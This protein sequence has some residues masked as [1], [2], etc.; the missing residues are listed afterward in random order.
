MRQNDKP[1]FSRNIIHANLKNKAGCTDAYQRHIQKRRRPD[2]EAHRVGSFQPN[3]ALI[4]AK[5]RE[6]DEQ[7]I[8]GKPP[9]I[10]IASNR[11]E[12]CRFTIVN[13]PKNGNIFEQI[14]DRCHYYHDQC[15]RDLR[16]QFKIHSFAEDTDHV[17]I[18]EA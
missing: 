16:S 8:R 12:E 13:S 9:K 18:I 3:H 4:Q 15:M 17:Q 2:K 11:C 1:A 10:S 14:C 5:A 7:L 6:H